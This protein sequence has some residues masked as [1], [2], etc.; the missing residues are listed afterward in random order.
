MSN[1]TVG[2]SANGAVRRAVELARGEVSE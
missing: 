1:I 2:A